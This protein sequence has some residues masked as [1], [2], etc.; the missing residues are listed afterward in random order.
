[1]PLASHCPLCPISASLSLPVVKVIIQNK[2]RI[3][4]HWEAHGRLTAL[5]YTAAS[6]LA[7]ISPTVSLVKEGAAMPLTD[8]DS[9]A[10]L[11]QVSVAET[12]RQQRPCRAGGVRRTE[13]GGGAG[14]V[15]AIGVISTSPETEGKTSEQM[16]GDRRGRSWRSPV[17]T[18]QKPYGLAEGWKR[19]A[20]RRRRRLEL[21]GQRRPGRVRGSSAKRGSWVQRNLHVRASPFMQAGL[22]LVRKTHV[23]KT[24]RPRDFTNCGSSGNAATR[25][26]RPPTRSVNKPPGGCTRAPTPVSDAGD[27]I[28][29][30]A[31]APL[32]E[33]L[34]RPG[35]EVRS[36]RAADVRLRSVRRGSSRNATRAMRGETGGGGGPSAD[37][38]RR[39][40]GPRAASIARNLH[41]CTRHG[42]RA[43]L[44][45][46]RHLSQTHSYSAA[47]RPR[48]RA[49]PRR[50]WRDAASLGGTETSQ[51]RRSR[52]ADS[53]QQSKRNSSPRLQHN[54]LRRH[55]NVK[56]V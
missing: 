21:R 46:S 31:A 4:T 42:E 55:D 32:A 35:G 27:R 25:T 50:R 29:A 11:Q 48:G 2:S 47:A 6:I 51:H 12:V 23:V 28:A 40:E 54:L 7:E 52:L 45:V 10:I 30:T 20:Q 39:K 41:V 38:E 49:R 37:S 17:S 43:R 5:L 34:R 13:G 44:P 3:A 15:A 16:P 22:P 56:S 26:R 18:V 36:R 14:V 19:F 9:S 53:G 8:D 33:I 24:I 1:M